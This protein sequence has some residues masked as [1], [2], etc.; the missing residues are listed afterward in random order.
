[1]VLVLILK[2][3]QDLGLAGDGLKYITVRYI[4]VARQENLS[5]FSTGLTGRSKNLNPTGFHLWYAQW[6]NTIHS[7]D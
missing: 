5:G 4:L 3:L 2:N 7:S 6:Q 1:M